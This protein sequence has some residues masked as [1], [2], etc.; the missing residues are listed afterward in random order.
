M[1]CCILKSC[2][3]ILLFFLH[4]DS[5]H[6]Y[7]SLTT[8]LLLGVH[9][10]MQHVLWIW[11]ALLFLSTLGMHNTTSLEKEICSVGAVAINELVSW[12]HKYA[13]AD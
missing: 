1:P 2:T 13:N 8:G 11:L 12:N 6:A 9:K 3:G 5:W 4:L 7:S 10:M